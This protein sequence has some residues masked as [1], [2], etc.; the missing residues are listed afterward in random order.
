MRLRAVLA[1]APFPLFA[2][3]PA[4]W[5]GLAFVGDIRRIAGRVV[6]VKVVY[7]D[8]LDASTMGAAVSALSPEAREHPLDDHVVDFVSR[9][10]PRFLAER[11]KPRRRV[12]LPQEEFSRREVTLTL[13]GRLCGAELY[14]HRSLPL[15]LVRAAVL[16][17][18]AAADVGIAAW[19]LSALDLAPKVRAVDVAFAE[20]FD[21]QQEPESP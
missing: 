8:A 13:A 12:L 15:Q 4:E 17:G 6:A 2:I 3:D 14:T 9:F 5:N 18:S 16:V 21:R 7:L 19:R 10:E 11:A 1:E 20:A